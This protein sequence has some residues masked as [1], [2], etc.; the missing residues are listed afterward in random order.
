SNISGRRGRIASI[1]KERGYRREA[2]LAAVL[3]LAS[4]AMVVWQNTRLTVL[5]DASYVLEN[6][7][8]I[9]AGDV[10]YRDFPFPYPPITFAVQAL[11]I[12][13]FGRAWWHHVA[14]AALSCGA[15]SALTFFIARSFTKP[16]AAFFL[17]LPLALLGSYCILPP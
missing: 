15:A 1:S 5:W 8:R 6:A 11:I 2:A 10:P 4:T 7:S 14:Y 9:A 13:I 12:K 17:S 3:F 16:L